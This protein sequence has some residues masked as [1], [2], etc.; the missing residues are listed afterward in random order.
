[1]ANHIAGI[2]KD[3][4]WSATRRFA[5]LCGDPTEFVYM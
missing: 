5:D 2:E 4:I 1:M 3:R